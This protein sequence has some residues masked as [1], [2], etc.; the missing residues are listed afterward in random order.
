M[1]QAAAVLALIAFCVFAGSTIST[2]DTD[3]TFVT[4]DQL[5]WGPAPPV[6]PP[7]AEAAVLSG[8]PGKKGWFVVALRGPQGY[9]VP[10]HWHST[11]E[12]VT[13]ISGSFTMGMG[14]SAGTAGT[15]LP[16]GGYAKMPAKMHHWGT[17]ASP[18]VIY[19][20]AMGPFDIHYIHAEDD[21]MKKAK[22]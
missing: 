18:F 15:T 4:P 8:D 13:V 5:K 21:P 20:S 22:K 7:G 6:L 9:T 10:P 11:T 16:V 17:A 19:I 1:K 3:H 14:D 12:N 2:A